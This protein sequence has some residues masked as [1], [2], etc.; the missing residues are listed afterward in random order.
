MK[1]EL[2]CISKQ[3]RQED[4]VPVDISGGSC[5]DSVYS[6]LANYLHG[7]FCIQP[8]EVGKYHA[9]NLHRNKVV[10]LFLKIQLLLH[11]HYPDFLTGTRGSMD[12][13]SE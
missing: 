3:L 9:K 5:V 11:K 1:M 4:S 13:H 10:I 6:L 8:Y 2:R 12:L 7:R